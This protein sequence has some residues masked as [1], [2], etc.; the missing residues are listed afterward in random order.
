MINSLNILIPEIFLTLS[1]FSVLM[2]GVF[3]KNSFNLVFNLS[4]VIIILTI[5][6]IFN[7]PSSEEKIFLDSFKRDIFSNYFKILILLSSLFVLNASKNFILD[8]NLAKFE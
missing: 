6:I 3:T 2:I 5:V 1:I 4:S 7:S 8:N